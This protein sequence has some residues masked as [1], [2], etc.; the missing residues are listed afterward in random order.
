MS[1]SRYLEILEVLGFATTIAF[2]IIGFLLWLKFAFLITGPGG[3]WSRLPP[4]M[5]LVLLAL[6]ISPVFFGWIISKWM[7]AG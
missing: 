3:L 5:A 6:L 4:G 1:E 7:S 2:P